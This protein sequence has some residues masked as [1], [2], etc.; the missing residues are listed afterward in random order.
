MTKPIDI[1]N[2]HLAGA[3]AGAVMETVLA[4]HTLLPEDK[5]IKLF[6]HLRLAYAFPSFD[7]RLLCIQARLQ[8]LSILGNKKKRKSIFLKISFYFKV[9][10]AAIQ[11]ANNVLYDGLIEEL[12]EVLNVRDPTLTV[13]F[14]KNK[15]H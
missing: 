7:Q 11:E 5:Q 12:V 2:V 14:K 9:Y 15:N 3:N 10:S 8:A 13:C 1:A 4:E 6:T